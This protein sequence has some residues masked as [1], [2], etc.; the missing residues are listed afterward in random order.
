MLAEPVSPFACSLDKR[1]EPHLRLASM[2]Y[3]GR[4][5]STR[6]EPLRKKARK[7]YE[8]SSCDRWYLIRDPSGALFIHHVSNMA[9]G[10]HVE[11]EEISAFMGRSAD[12]EH[13]ELLRLIGT[14]V[15]EHPAQ[16]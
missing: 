5:T 16:A 10:G 4:A 6:Q 2:R 13:Q 12:P 1:R 11:H 14:P 15:E 7:L 3:S 8:R 9:S